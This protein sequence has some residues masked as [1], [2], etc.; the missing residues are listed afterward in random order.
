MK[1]RPLHAL[2]VLAV[3][4][5]TIPGCAKQGGEE[6]KDRENPRPLVAVRAVE[7]MR[8]DAVQT[9]NATGRTDV[10]RRHKILSPVAGTIR[11][12]N[13]L[14]GTAVDAHQVVATVVTKESQS[15]I[16]GAEAL[17]RLAQTPEQKGEA[18]RALQLA[19]NTENA[20]TITAPFSGVV[21]SRTVN[22]GELVAENSEICTLLDL[23]ST[24]FM[25]EVPL[26]DVA[27]IHS[28]MTARVHL[29]SF[30]G[31][32]LAAVVDAVLPRTDMQS[33][34][35]LVRLRLKGHGSSLHLRPDMGG[36][37][38]IA[39]GVHKDALLV[40]RSAV[41]RDDEKNATSIVI[42][43]PDSLALSVPVE[44]GAS[45]DSTV[46]VLSTALKGGVLVITEG[47]Y[48]IPDSTRITVNGRDAR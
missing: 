13:V 24:V 19:K 36:T 34:T 2:A 23:A 20:V 8:G 46:E 21:A 5:L 11:M 33:Q 4:S 26:R 42:V 15:A 28:G 32:D 31:H 25:A 14:E 22:P 43:T 39:V 7:I 6:D 37:V 38:D 45:T 18:E 44:I 27:R 47:N 9:L 12:L 48:A 40:P 3:L 17:G 10:L 16:A 30:E 29:G 35:T 1:P 41:L